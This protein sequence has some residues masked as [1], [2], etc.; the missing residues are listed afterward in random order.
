M[1]FRDML[2]SSKRSGPGPGALGD[3]EEAGMGC[4]FYEAVETRRSV[5]AYLPDPVPQE[6]LDRCLD[7]ARKAASSSNLQH[8]EFVIIR[9]PELRKEAN[10]ICLDQ[11]GPAQAPLLVAVVAHMDTWKRTSRFML[12]TLRQRGI[13]RPSQELY[14]GKQVPLLYTQGPFGALGLVRKAAARILSLFRPTPTFMSRCDLRVLAN[15]STA[16]AAATFMLALRAEGYD[17]C[18]MEGFDPWRAKR[19]LNLG[20]G[21]EVCMFLSVGKRGPEAVWWD[22]IL[23]PREWS[24][25]EL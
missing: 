2:E 10:A 4:D 23:V 1:A 6:A 14:W 21:A 5:R 12:D 7:A 20:P 9:D 19:L 25:R 8:W 15:K 22:R 3:L 24:V 16:L 17:T 11:R 18:P 13:V